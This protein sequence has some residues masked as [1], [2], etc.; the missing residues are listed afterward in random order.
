[1]ITWINE[2]DE[3]NY[4]NGH[5][6]VKRFN[7][8]I[9][10]RRSKYPYDHNSHSEIIEN[11]NT[12]GYHIIKGAFD[13]DK[14]NSLNQEVEEAI[15]S[16]EN[17]KI[18]DPYWKVINQPLINCSKVAFDLATDSSRIFTVITSLKVRAL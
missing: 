16:G 13:A 3:R 17:L 7:E 14:L 12:K 15:N 5:L 18:N 1:M 8:A 4:L 11:I 9:S 10:N 2:T 6:G